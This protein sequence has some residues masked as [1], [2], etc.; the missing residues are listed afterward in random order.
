MKKRSWIIGAVAVLL[1]VGMIGLTAVTAGADS[2]RM[3]EE[4]INAVVNTQTDATQITSP[5]I[6]VANQVRNSV[7]GVNNYASAASYYGYG[8]YYGYGRQPRSEDVLRGTGSGVVITE[9]GHVLT[10]YHVVENSSR[11]TVTTAQDQSEHEAQVVGYDADLDI[12]VLLVPDLN[13][14]AVPLG[15]SDQLQVGEWAIVIGNPLGEDFA[16]TLTVGVV[17]A[18]D[19]QITDSTL[20]RYGRR[21]TVTN[22][23]IQV[24]AAVNS[25]NSGGGMFNTLGQLQ[26]IPARKYSSNMLFSTS[27]E[28]IG[29][30]I[31]I[32]VAKPLIAQVLKDYDGTAVSA[33]AEPKDAE[34]EQIAREPLKGK[35]RLGIVVTTLVSDYDRVLP[36]GALVRS[37]DA[38][39]PAEK[40]GLQAGD[41]I[42]EC[43]GA[44]IASSDELTNK[45]KGFQEG[46]SVTLKVYRDTDLQQQM[47]ENYIDY[48]KLGK[49]Y[50]WVEITVQLKVLDQVDRNS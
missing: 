42:V 15:D 37:V 40:A 1:A 35:P 16:R 14:P 21:T 22:T 31:P 25:G 18:I 45:L 11:V 3:T 19:R 34:N 41:I 26:G 9:Y 13:L 17:S 27:I 5:F 44:I 8:Y 24:D 47:R 2:S 49:N 28:S 29:M 39:S 10:N 30:C 12:A 48:S 6:E 43:D 32:N 33:Q 46:D 23:M 20:D 50:D 4:E 7:V 36:Q 38:G